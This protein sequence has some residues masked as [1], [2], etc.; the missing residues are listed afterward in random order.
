MLFI[1]L[2][3]AHYEK[4]SIKFWPKVGSSKNKYIS[5][6]YEEEFIETE[7]KFEV[8]LYIRL[9]AVVTI[10]LK[11]VSV[12]LPGEIFKLHLTLNLNINL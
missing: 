5:C 9:S 10:F 6:F 8:P 3:Q 1:S 2:R 4:R 12:T 11:K 7:P